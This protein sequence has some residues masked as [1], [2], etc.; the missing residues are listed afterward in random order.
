MELNHWLFVTE[1]IVRPCS[2][3]E[4]RWNR[5]LHCDWKM[6]GKTARQAIDIILS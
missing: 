6:V 4:D 3:S 2:F 5:L 1:G